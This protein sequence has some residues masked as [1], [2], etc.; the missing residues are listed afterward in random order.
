MILTFFF[1]FLGGLGEI[2]IGST[3]E[4]EKEKIKYWKIEKQSKMKESKKNR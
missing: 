3:V 2:A 1:F 4:K